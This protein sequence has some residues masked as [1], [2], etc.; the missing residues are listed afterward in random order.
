MSDLRHRAEELV[1]TDAELGPKVARVLEASGS[2]MEALG[3]AVS[4][5]LLSVA[6]EAVGLLK[7]RPGNTSWDGTVF[8]MTF[9]IRPAGTFFDQDIKLRLWPDYGRMVVNIIVDRK[10]ARPV[11]GNFGFGTA[12]SRA[13]KQVADLISSILPSR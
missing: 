4:K 13:G 10:G 11:N 9:T 12:Q 7:S 8:S 2:L 5:Y 3:D 1:A 6:N